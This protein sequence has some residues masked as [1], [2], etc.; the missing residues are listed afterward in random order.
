M[1]QKELYQELP[2]NNWDRVCLIILLIEFTVFVYAGIQR[3]G[4]YGIYPTLSPLAL[5][6][7]DLGIFALFSGI[8][9]L[10]I[11]IVKLASKEVMREANT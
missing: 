2:M 1:P 9:V 3:Y 10:I 8:T 6:W 4:V 11:F 5:G 7:N